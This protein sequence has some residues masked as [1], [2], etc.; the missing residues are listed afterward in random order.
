MYFFNKNYFIKNNNY[1]NWNKNKY[2]VINDELQMFD[3]D[4]ETDFQVGKS[5]S[6]YLKYNFYS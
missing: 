5:I 6:K 1:W 3:I 4:T 2:M